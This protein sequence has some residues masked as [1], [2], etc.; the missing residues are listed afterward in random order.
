MRSSSA[1][2]A[3]AAVSFSIVA[4]LKRQDSAIPAGL[5]CNLIVSDH[6]GALLRSVEVAEPEDR[7]LAE[8]SQP[9]RLEAPMAGKNRII[10]V[11]DQRI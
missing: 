11:D 2:R 10:V 1:H 7:N 8:A 6:I 4:E 5:F 3:S 9:R